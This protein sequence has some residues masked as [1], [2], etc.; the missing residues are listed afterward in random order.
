MRVYALDVGKAAQTT[1]ANLVPAAAVVGL[2]RP[3]A[4]PDKP[5]IAVLPFQNMSDDPQEKYFVDE[6]VEDITPGLARIRRL[7]VIARAW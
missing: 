3:L 4:L 6:I 5:S 7:F 1:R 2:P